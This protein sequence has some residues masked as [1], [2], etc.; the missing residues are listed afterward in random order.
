MDDVAA[1]RT[2]GRSADADEQKPTLGTAGIGPAVRGVSG[3]GMNPM[4]TG[5]LRRPSEV[6]GRDPGQARR[7]S[8]DD[9]WN[10][11]TL[12][13]ASLL[14]HGRTYDMSKRESCTDSSTGA[15]F[16]LAGSYGLPPGGRAMRGGPGHA[17]TTLSGGVG[18]S[19]EAG[20]QRHGLTPQLT[21]PGLGQGAGEMLGSAVVTT[22]APGRAPTPPQGGGGQAGAAAAGELREDQLLSTTRLGAPQLFG[23]GQGD[24]EARM[25]PISAML[26]LPGGPVADD[27]DRHAP[28]SAFLEFANEPGFASGPSGRGAGGA[29][30]S[31]THLVMAAMQAGQQFRSASLSSLSMQQMAATPGAGQHGVAGL[32]GQRQGTV[33]G[34]LGRPQ[35]LNLPG[36]GGY[37]AVNLPGPGYAAAAAMAAAG[38]VGDVGLGG[39]RDAAAAAQARASRQLKRRRTSPHPSIARSASGGGVSGLEQGGGVQVP[40]SGPAPSSQPSGLRA[41]VRDSGS[42]RR[43]Q[44]SASGGT[45]SG[46]TASAG[47][48]QATASAGGG[49]TLADA[50][51]SGQLG[52]GAPAATTVPTR[53]LY[54]SDDED[55]EFLSQGESQEESSSQGTPGEEREGG[56]T[57]RGGGRQGGTASGRGGGGSL[58]MPL[59]DVSDGGFTGGGGSM[60]EIDPV[61][62]QMRRRALTQEERMLRNREA[63]AKSRARR[64]QYQQSLEQHILALQ[65]HSAALRRLLEQN[66]ISLPA[67][68]RE[69]QAAL[70][71]GLP[72]PPRRNSPP[73]SRKGIGGA[74]GSVVIAGAVQEPRLSV[75][76]LT[77][78]AKTQVQAGAARGGGIAPAWSQPQ[79]LGA[80]GAAGGSGLAGASLSAP[81][82]GA[83]GGLLAPGG[84]GQQGVH[85]GAGGAE[86][87]EGAAA[88]QQHQDHFDMLAIGSYSDLMTTLFS[89]GQA[90]TATACFVPF[91]AA[92]LA[93]RGAADMPPPHRELAPAGAT[94]PHSRKVPGPLRNP[95]GQDQLRPRYPRLEEDVTADVVVVGAGLS[96]LCTA[97][98]LLRAGKSVV[99]LESK[100][101]GSGSSGRGLGMIS[102]WID[103]TYLEVE[104]TLGLEA[105]RAVSASHRAAADFVRG[106]VKEEGIEC[107]LEEVEAAVAARLEPSPASTRSQQAGP[108]RPQEG[109]GNSGAAADARGEELSPYQQQQLEWQRRQEERQARREE[110]RAARALR[111]ELAAC[112]RAGVEGS[113][114]AFRRRAGGESDELLLLPGGLN[115][116]P[117]RL[118]QGLAEA[119][120]R[121]G[122][123]IY[124]HSRAKG[125]KAVI[126]ATHSPINR[127]QLWVHD[128]QLPKRSYT[129]GIEVHGAL[130]QQ[131]QDEKQYG[132]PWGELEAWARERFPMSGRTLYCW[133]G[134]DYYPADLLGLYGRDP[135]DL[136]RPPVY[137]LT[138]H[139][140]QE[141]TGAVLGSEAVAGTITGA[142][143]PWAPAY[144]PSRFVP[145][146]LAKYTRELSLY[147]GTVAAALLKHVVPRSLEDHL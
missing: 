68:L 47:A 76:A 137:V 147:F 66:G 86:A 98:R 115:L 101:V 19:A 26:G 88:G 3:P 127:N 67:P 106:L 118:L 96:G 140:G 5:M 136:S 9:S 54:M 21:G 30:P 70:G 132:D 65:T 108:R 24:N 82:P 114:V 99:V 57:R 91:C 1:G 18:Q 63:A 74:G 52:S 20:E 134:S 129:L 92:L 58:L 83:G 146:A 145:G 29:P 120:T 139:G 12:R 143:P 117:L 71:D 89:E 32:L 138:G 59:G 112:C 78:L 103:D 60:V 41:L 28:A 13:T 113:H 102:P 7:P 31:P 33:D 116:Q 109:V 110:E 64:H 39:E 23:P 142:P 16:L 84:G 81:L 97:Y 56:R 124:E 37:E 87:A 125:G 48:G 95:W 40:S 62:G 100:V 107:G 73:R 69:Q 10:P 2:A 80:D 11:E 4:E 75:S 55:A 122:G 49:L 53:A 15:E 79:P 36:T 25:P 17:A 131:G 61:T 42:V 128:R 44:N 111:Q 22:G 133:S 35:S 93:S 72:P 50:A 27:D 144:R 119:V 46:P 43:R 141:W 77:G 130:H 14:S 94:L 34:P 45:G 51:G 6:A 90:R 123:R 121:R 38:V 104:R 126:L 8:E 85:G 105:A 135:L